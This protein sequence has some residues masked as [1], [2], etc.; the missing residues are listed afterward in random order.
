MVETMILL[1]VS[2]LTSSEPFSSA[3]RSSWVVDPWE[4]GPESAMS[5]YEMGSDELIL[6]L[7]V[8]CM[9]LSWTRNEM[10]A[11]SRQGPT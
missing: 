6:G 9:R 2:S 3:V 7:N 11:R 1:S 10:G 4:D 5:V 8:G